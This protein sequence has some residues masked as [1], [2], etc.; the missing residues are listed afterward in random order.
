MKILVCGPA[1]KMDE[2]LEGMEGKRQDVVFAEKWNDTRDMG[3]FDAFL[4]L[5]EYG[6]AIED[7]QCDKPVFIDE[8]TRTL[9]E[10]NAPTNVIRINGWPGFLNRKVW[11][12]SGKI[13]AEAKAAAAI[14]GKELI[15]VK[16][17]PGL[18]A[19]TVV[20]MI[21]NEAFIVLGEGLSSKE[22]ID[23]A[24]KAAT[25]Y[26]YGPFEWGE[27]IG[28]KNVYQLLRHLSLEDSRYIPSF[29]PDSV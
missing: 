11:E 5:G 26:P 17:T 21:I 20:S 2:L 28:W 19:A 27:M 23:I 25:N 6:V 29:S 3:Q 12:A 10:M 13:N 1:Q 14:F 24:M 7:L 8:V 18:V 15:E 16:D 22:E 4:L 9:T